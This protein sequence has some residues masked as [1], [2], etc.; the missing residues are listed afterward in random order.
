MLQEN[1]APYPRG[2]KKSHIVVGNS[3]TLAPE[4]VPEAMQSLLRWFKENKKKMFPLQ[5]AIEFHLRF[6]RI[7]PFENGNGR[8][9]RMLMNKILMANDMTPLTIFAENR[10]AYFRAIEKSSDG[11]L[12]PLYSFILDQYVKTLR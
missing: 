9:G 12:T 11:R 2:Y 5:L 3:P 10:R 7:H 4:K 1:G 8:V 6:E